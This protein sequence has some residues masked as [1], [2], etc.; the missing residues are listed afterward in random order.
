MSVNGLQRIA[1][2]L[3]PGFG[4][5]S[6]AAA[7]ETLAAT[8]QL[9]EGGG[10]EGLLLSPQGG[11]VRTNTGAEVLTT[12]LSETAVQAVF[13]VS[14]GPWQGDHPLA[15]LLLP[16]L[17]R[18][19]EAGLVMGAI[20][21]G[22]AWL[23]EAGLLRGRRA[24]VHW[25]Q[26]AALAERH[27]DLIVSQQLF[28]IDGQRLSCAGQTA[29]QDMLIHWLGQQQGER[30]AQ[31]LVALLGLERLRGREERQR[32]PQAARPGGGSAKLAEALQLMEANLAEPLPTE[33]IARLVG[34]SR[35]QLERLFKQHMDALP[36]RWYVGL[37]LQLAQRMLRQSS[38]SILQ[39]G[40]SCGFASA[41][42]FSN[43]YRAHFGHTPRDERSQHA[44]AWRAAPQQEAR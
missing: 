44:A 24:T 28:E 39:I 22:A 21:S 15:S 33:D 43:A 6:L 7:L 8:Q 31:S 27:P 37:R 13:V 29:S 26:I 42:H 17:R 19:A 2:V 16:W 34:L 10:Y 5:Q 36:S 18:Q 23:A 20:G 14:D 30:V 38:Q 35:R 32:Q 3:L 1:F 25:P 41:S 40:L 9:S 11:P 4:L 12:A